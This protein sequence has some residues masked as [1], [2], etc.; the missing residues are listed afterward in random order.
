MA[1]IF[2]HTSQLLFFALSAAFLYWLLRQNSEQMAQQPVS[3]RSRR[4]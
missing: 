3:K 2:Y 4:R 1:D